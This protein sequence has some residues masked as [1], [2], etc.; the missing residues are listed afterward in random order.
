ML[1]IDAGRIKWC[2]L[3]AW[4]ISYLWPKS[5]H[6][7]I[8][9]IAPQSAR[10]MIELPPPAKGSAEKS[11]DSIGL[12]QAKPSQLIMPQVVQSVQGVVQ[13]QLTM[14][15]LQLQTLLQPVVQ[16]Q[17]CRPQ[18]SLQLHE[19]RFIPSGRYGPSYK[20]TLAIY[21]LVG[22]TEQWAASNS[23]KTILSTIGGLPK[24]A[25]VVFLRSGQY[26]LFA[27]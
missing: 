7:T 16:L 19:P 3:P 22:P 6:G 14:P 5:A 12:L 8:P 20:R 11:I 9:T 10:S 23:W 4:A 15:Q 17:F 18:A 13:L 26:G 27:L 21:I 2:T 24:H 25:P 1:T